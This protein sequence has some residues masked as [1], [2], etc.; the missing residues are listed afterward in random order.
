MVNRR[1]D[2][3]QEVIPRGASRVCAVGESAGGFTIATSVIRYLLISA[4]CLAG[5][6]A[7]EPMAFFESKV[8][9]LLL[10]HCIECHGGEKTKGGLRLTHRAGWETGGDSGPAL[11]PGKPDESLLIRAVR[12]RDDNLSMPPERKLSDAQIAVLEEWVRLGAADPRESAPAAESAPVAMTVEEGRKFWAWQPV[13]KPSLPA[14]QDTAWPRTDV[15]RFVLAE[16][17]THGLKPGLDAEAQVLARRLS[18]ALTGLPPDVSDVSDKADT[19]D[20]AARLLTSP[21]FAERMASHWLDLTRFAES[22]G[23][24]R[25]LLFKDAWRYRDYVINAYREDRPF[26]HMIREQ[27]AGDLL[28]SES[29]AERERQ[30]T[31]TAFLALGPTNYEEQ[32]KQ[33]LRFDII[34]EQLDTLGKV[35]MGQT[36]GCA[37]CHDHKFD[38]IPQRDYYSLFGILAHTPMDRVWTNDE[39]YRDAAKKLSAK[40][41]SSPEGP[42]SALKLKKGELLADFANGIPPGWTVVGEAEITRGALRTGTLSRRLPAR[43]RSPYFTITT[44]NVDILLAAREA[45]M[46]VSVA[47]L[48]VIREPIYNGLRR[49]PEDGQWRWNRFQVG[50]WK[51]QRAYVEIW[52]GV[53]QGPLDMS[54]GR[55]PVF[56]LRALAAV[57]GDEPPVPPELEIERLPRD[58]PPRSAEALRI[59]TQLP[60]PDWFLAVA[61]PAKGADTPVFKRGDA[62]QPDAPAPRRFLSALE[63]TAGAHRVTSGSGRKELADAVLAENNPLTWRVAANRVWLWL[64]G[65]GL[66]RTP[67]D[68]GKL[69][70]TPV[71]PELLDLLAWRLQH[72][73]RGQLKPFIRELMLSQAWRRASN[74]PADSRDPDNRLLA[75][76]PL[77]RLEAEELR[78]AMLAVSGRLDRTLGGPAV[79]ARARAKFFTNTI[80]RYENGVPDGQGRR[81]LYLSTRRNYPDAFLAIFDQPAPVTS[82]TRR[83][84]SNVPAQAL[85]M[86]N[87][88]MVATLAEHWG[89]RMATAPG[90]VPQRVQQMHLAAF[91]RSATSE[92]LAECTALLAS[93]SPDSDAWT[94]LA[95][96]LFNTKEFLWIE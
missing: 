52:T 27:L 5:A 49:T 75:R 31:A 84:V 85:A 56:A 89:R 45:T 71:L 72:T 7:A 93:D 73:H 33:Q 3:R 41:L 88:P 92:E 86:M 28:P 65:E 68:F 54:P 2:R 95:L 8:R 79:P 30:L 46:I 47:N 42:V 66:C 19:S 22:S 4:A 67:D 14:V 51:G 13:R 57:D 34:D 63:S 25:T 40:N 58:A 21:H 59:E 44:E 83:N 70:D 9:P 94:R 78:D 76:F 23:G 10:E 38:P 11:V 26:D 29:P 96:A 50:R 37:R 18:F 1:M 16:M 62:N 74:A 91:A 61:E 48:Q 12:Y 80:D 32:D 43:V 81:S 6:R 60:R 69:G 87:D 35:F 55:S 64:F 82:F 90:D 15:D 24:G 36:I 77:R 39:I 17:E 53:A 20:L